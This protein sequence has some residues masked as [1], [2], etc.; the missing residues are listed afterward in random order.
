MDR[1]KI[2][3]VDDEK[4]IL[5][6]YAK[7][8]E[9]AGH[10]VYKAINGQE[11]IK[12]AQKDKPDI[13]FT[14]LIMPGMDGVEVCKKIKELYPDAE[15]V[16]VSGHPEDAAKNQVNFIRAGGRDE[17]LRKPLG[18]DELSNT[19]EKILLRR[20]GKFGK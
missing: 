6:A 1:I 14:D 7:E 8:L 2:L 11:A 5:K 15:I 4:I 19:V 20:G 17:W 12:I 13:V 18:P 3:L 9:L 10:D 16:L